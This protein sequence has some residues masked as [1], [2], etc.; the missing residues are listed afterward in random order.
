MTTPASTLEY[1]VVIPFFNEEGAVSTLLPELRFTM[2]QLGQPFE[3]ILVDDGSVDATLANLAAF[4]A[5][6]PACRCVSFARN[7]GQATA[8]LRGCQEAKGR[9]II[10]LDGD[11][12]N[13]PEDIP[14]MI[15]AAARGFDMVVGIRANRQDTWLRRSMSRLA[16]AVRGRL[17]RDNLRDSGCALKIFRREIVASFWEIRSLYSFMPAFAISAGWR[18]TEIPVRHRE[19]R[20]GASKY[21]FGTFA[22]RPMVDLLALWWLLRFRRLTASSSDQRRAPD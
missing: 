3:V 5:E 11:G 8:L 15:A 10:T 1:S 22:W 13:N 16:N 12:Q 14:K 20:T 19:R 17:L 21:G 4:A 2:D 18:V 9:W 7:Q 6:W